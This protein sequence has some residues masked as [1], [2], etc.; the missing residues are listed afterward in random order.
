MNIINYLYN[1]SKSI[2]N[3]N[4]NAYNYNNIENENLISNFV[5][6]S[7]GYSNHSCSSKSSSRTLMVSDRSVRTGHRKK[8]KEERPAVVKAAGQA[9]RSSARSA[10]RAVTSASALG[11]TINHS[12]RSKQEKNMDSREDDQGEKY[13]NYEFNLHNI[14]FDSKVYKNRCDGVCVLND[15]IYI[16]D[17]IKK[18][19]YLYTPYNNVWYI[20]LNICEEMSVNKNGNFELTN[21]YSKKSQEQ[22]IEGGFHHLN[23]ISFMNYTDVVYLNNCIFIISSNCHFMNFC[24]V[25]MINMNTLFGTIVVESAQNNFADFAELL[26]MLRGD[27][28]DRTEQGNVND[29][30]IDHMGEPSNWDA[31]AGGSSTLQETTRRP[32]ETNPTV[33]CVEQTMCSDEAG[34]VENDHIQDKHRRRGDGNTQRQRSSDTQG[35]HSDEYVSGISEFSEFSELSELGEFSELFP[36]EEKNYFKK[37]KRVIK[38]RD[39]FS[40]CSVNDSCYSLIYLFGG[41]GSTIKRANEYIDIIY[42]DL[43][44]YDFYRN[45]WMELYQYRC[46]QEGCAPEER[47]NPEEAYQDNSLLRTYLDESTGIRGDCGN[48]LS[49]KSGGIVSPLGTQNEHTME[50]DTRNGEEC[51][52]DSFF[53]LNSNDA[54]SNDNT[55][56]L[57]KV[58]MDEGMENTKESLR[59]NVG[60]VD[61]IATVATSTAERHIDS[62]SQTKGGS[63]DRHCIN[64]DRREVAKKEEEEAN[65]TCSDLY[66]LIF[67]TH[68]EATDAKARNAEFRDIHR[69]STPVEEPQQIGTNIYHERNDPPCKDC[70]QRKKCK[71]ICD[72]IS[73]G[74]KIRSIPWLGKRA[75]HSCTYYKNNLYIFGGISYYSFNRNKINLK[76]CDNLF[77]YNIQSNKCFEIMAKGSIPE[78]RYRHGCVIINDYMFIIGGECKSSSLPRNDLFF[79]DFKTSVW[80]E[81]VIN[82][83][84]GSHSLYKTVWLENFGSI[85]MFGSSI[86]RLT[87]KNF[88]YTP[89]YKNNN[90]RVE[91]RRF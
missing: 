11:R 51:F 46:D 77:L 91:N 89:S 32:K 64:G 69:E 86:L 56:Q 57:S 61:S 25:N 85:Y 41:K 5:D 49:F 29:H 8:G 4:I 74:V 30:Q 43:Y 81:V 52:N 73:N 55:T 38:A 66:N 1:K 34:M 20:F 36:N 16:F 62:F 82:S 24:K 88:Q 14:G 19:I 75:G 2:Y 47:T 9:V 23:N 84:V 27:K 78:K 65:E 54:F 72:L 68:E 83:K 7:N 60:T 33:T 40:I 28:T 6:I 22:T 76:F 87:K 15:N 48:T 59:R 58:K 21:F 13:K 17:K 70:M 63:L 12:D 71:Y 79:Y 90:K 53:L 45:R 35:S 18:C 3:R 37:M 42:N 10:G 31:K 26:R 50:N 80:T 67:D 39:F 44:V